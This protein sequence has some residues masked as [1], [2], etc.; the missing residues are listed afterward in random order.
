MLRSIWRGVLVLVKGAA[1][2][3]AILGVLLMAAVIWFS[4]NPLF[5]SPETGE[6]HASA[7]RELRLEAGQTTLAI[8][9]EARLNE[10]AVTPDSGR[11]DPPTLLAAIVPTDG[12]PLES[13]EF[14]IAP[15]EATSALNDLHETDPGRLRWTIDCPE[16]TRDGCRHRVVLLVEAKPSQVDRTWR[17]TVTGN[18]RY[19]TFVRTPGWSSFD[20]DLGSVGNEHGMGP[21]PL[22]EANGAVELTAEQ[23]V[24]VVPLRLEHSGTRE[25]GNLPAAALRVAIDAVRLTETAPAGLDA[26]EP[27]RVTVLDSDGAVLAKQAIRPGQG[28]RRS[29]GGARRAPCWPRIPYRRPAGTCRRGWRRRRGPSLAPAPP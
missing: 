10:N 21:S 13:V 8:T 14:R 15:A 3:V 7:S 9:L 25:R 19:P 16:G 1:V 22:A 6:L 5:P 27:V 4:F 17:L 28:G 20:L 26:P 12:S 29:R 11:P 2:L 24:V 23:P 18:M